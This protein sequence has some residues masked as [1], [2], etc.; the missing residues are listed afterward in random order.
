MHALERFAPLTG[1]VFVVLVIVA[2][3][4]IGE[5]PAADD[6]LAEVV[7]FWDDNKDSAVVA[8]ILGAISSAFLL[9]FAATLRGALAD[10]E[11]GSRRLS[12]TAFGGA[13]I[14]TAGWLI[15]IGCTFAAADTVGDVAPEVTQALSVLQADLFFPL[16]V[17]FGVFLLASGLAIL[18]WG[19]L[20]SWTGW[21]A[22]VLGVA[23][24][25]PAGFFA[26]VLMLAWIVA[27]SL[28]L[29][30]AANPPT[31]RGVPEEA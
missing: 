11:G 17:G 5:T 31:S 13:V 30:M 24:F 27:V 21:V 20:P 7:N 18:R 2:T 22:L 25:T 23:A 28:M 12:S 15:L 16:A 1:I 4:I 3:I 6:P 9:W 10:A 26:I 29:F 14:G 19:A 8:S